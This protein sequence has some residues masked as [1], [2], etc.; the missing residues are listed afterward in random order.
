VSVSTSTDAVASSITITCAIMRAIA[1]QLEA[2]TTDLQ[3]TNSVRMLQN[4]GAHKHKLVSIWFSMQSENTAC[5]LNACSLK[6]TILLPT[7][8]AR[9]SALVD[10]IQRIYCGWDPSAESDSSK[11]EQVN[12]CMDLKH[13]ALAHLEPT[14]LP[15]QKSCRCPALKLSPPWVTSVCNPSVSESR[16]K[17][18]MCT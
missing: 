14:H 9:S 15:K 2:S 3:Q 5:S 7:F 4:D 17:A 8:A 12:R 6:Y 13:S 11:S 16:T 1:C 10:G 18:S